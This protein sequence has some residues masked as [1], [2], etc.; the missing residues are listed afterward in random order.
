MKRENSLGKNSLF[1]THEKMRTGAEW[2]NGWNKWRRPEKTTGCV[3]FPPIP[4]AS[5]E[6]PPP[7]AYMPRRHLHPLFLLFIFSAHPPTM[8]IFNAL[9]GLFNLKFYCSSLVPA[10]KFYLRSYLK[11]ILRLYYYNV[12]NLT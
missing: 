12:S 4:R 11:E 6:L 3:L 5:P 10:I 2:K 8:P 1:M 9:G 7:L